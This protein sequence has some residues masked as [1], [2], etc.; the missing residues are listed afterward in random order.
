MGR[1]LR[2]VRGRAHSHHWRLIV[3][4]TVRYA[5]DNPPSEYVLTLR[6]Y[7]LAI[8]LA[9]LSGFSPII[10]T[11]PARNESLLKD[12]GATH[13]LVRAALS[14]AE[15]SNTIKGITSKPLMLAFDTVT[16]PDGQNAAYDA[17]APGGK[18]VHFLP[19]HIDESRRTGD[20]QLFTVY[21]SV[22]PPFRRSFG[23]NMWKHLPTMLAAG[24]I[25]VRELAQLFL[26]KE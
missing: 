9:R 11:A 23:V 17:V 2:Q 20:K 21:G 16:P 13:V 10:T 22:Y 5:R 14:L 1:G 12:L 25:K 15:L 7:F 4:R 8:Q 18:F 19:L 24:E 26:D 6:D 3:R